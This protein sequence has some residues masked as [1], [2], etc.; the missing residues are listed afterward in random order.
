MFNWVKN[1]FGKEKETKTSVDVSNTLKEEVVEASKTV[2]A[3]P[4]SKPK[5]TAAKKAPAAT[6]APEAP[7][8]RGRK[9]KSES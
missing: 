2:E 9:P 7:K 8:K 3:K 1:L 5:R 4:V 6:P